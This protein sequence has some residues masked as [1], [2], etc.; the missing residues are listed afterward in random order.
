MKKKRKFNIAI[1]GLG[2]IGLNLYRYLINNKKSIVQKNNVNFEVKYVSAKNIKKKRKFK[3]PKNKWL[4]NYIHASKLKDIDL[5]VELIGGSEGPAKKL[6]FNAIKNKKHV[7]TANKSLISK[8]GNKLAIIAEKNKVN[9]EF[10]AAVAGGIPIIRTL[11]EGLIANKNKKVYGILNGTSNYILSNLD[12]T[13]MNF[14]KV[15]GNAKEL[16]Y[17]ESNPK[18]D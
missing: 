17:A 2:N 7:V 9:V 18:S 8:Y 3:I 14:E 12:K 15:L 6:V 4:K 10:E 13:N 5:I 16:G 1:V 11:K